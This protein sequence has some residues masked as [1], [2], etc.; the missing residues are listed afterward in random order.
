MKKCSVCKEEKS[1]D[2]FFKDTEYPDQQHP[3]CRSCN[4][5]FLKSPKVKRKEKL[6][7][8]KYRYK[9]RYNLTVDQYNELLQEQDNRCAICNKHP[10][11]NRKLAVD[12]CHKEGHVRGLLCT[13][14]NVGLGNFK[15]NTEFLLKAVEYLGG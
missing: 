2:S 14:C 12:H 1:I 3:S 15:D 11:K 5:L 13:T 10:P 9:T 7:A 4:A 8:R 6:A